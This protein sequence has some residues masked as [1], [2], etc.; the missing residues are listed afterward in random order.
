MATWSSEEISHF[1]FCMCLP[2]AMPPC[3]SCT[4]DNGRKPP[5]CCA[6]RHTCKLLPAAQVWTCRIA[7]LASTCHTHFV[8]FNVSHF[9]QP[10]YCYR[11]KGCRQESI[12]VWKVIWGLEVPAEHHCSIATVL[13]FPVQNLMLLKFRTVNFCSFNFISQGF[14]GNIQKF[15]PIE[16]FV[17]HGSWDQLSRYCYPHSALSISTSSCQGV[18]QMIHN[19]GTWARFV[20]VKG[21]Q[22]LF[23]IAIYAVSPAAVGGE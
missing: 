6:V 23:G 19:S 22:E 18:K 13:G 4:S 11:A 21:F 2:N 20:T 10:D 14:I 16:N 15:A 9:S 7:P 8:Y 12:R 1:Y 3:F 17:L 5:G